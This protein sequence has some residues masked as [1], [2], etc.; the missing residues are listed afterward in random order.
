MDIDGRFSFV[1][2]AAGL[3]GSRAAD[4]ARFKRST[5]SSKVTTFYIFLLS[6][7]AASKPV[8]A[9]AERGV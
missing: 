7:G 4:T 9:T 3:A 8:D 2:P 6:Q 5:S 1:R